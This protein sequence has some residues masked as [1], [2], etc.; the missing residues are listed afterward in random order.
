MLSGFR[1]IELNISFTL[2]SNV[3]FNPDEHVWSFSYAYV[4]GVTYYKQYGGVFL[5]DIHILQDSKG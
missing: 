5:K 1:V 2:F 4:I 3:S